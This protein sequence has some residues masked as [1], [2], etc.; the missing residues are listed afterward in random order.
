MATPV[1][2]SVSQATRLVGILGEQGVEHA[3]GDLVGQLVRMAH[4]DRFAGEQI[5][6]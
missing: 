1:V 2:T 3:V 4:A 6:A 5:L